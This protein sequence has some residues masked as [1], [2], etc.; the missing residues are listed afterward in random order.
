MER[1]GVWVHLKDVEKECRII[2]YGV[3]AGPLI[4]I[5]YD[6]NPYNNNNN[7]NNNNDNDNNNN[8][9]K[10][11]Y[12]APFPLSPMT[13]YI[14]KRNRKVSLSHLWRANM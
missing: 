5:I 6:W 13:L 14:K 12:I 7:N 1:Q 4:S 10:K 11:I 8:N 3:R 9:T 2:V